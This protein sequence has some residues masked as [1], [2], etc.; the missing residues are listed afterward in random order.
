MTPARAANRSMHPHD[1]DPCQAFKAFR[2]YSMA[3]GT[4]ILAAALGVASLMWSRVD[5]LDDRCQKTGQDVA[6]I[7]AQIRS[8]ESSVNRLDQTIRDRMPRSLFPPA[9]Q[10]QE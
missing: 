3:V 9:Y 6:G 7:T 8:L 4:G 10:P 5:R 2:H 1:G